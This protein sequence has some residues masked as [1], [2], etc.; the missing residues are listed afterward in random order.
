MQTKNS[1]SGTAKNH[2]PCK[3]LRQTFAAEEDL[4]H[5]LIKKHCENRH[6]NAL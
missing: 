3:H 6:K 2:T 4:L 1:L 5:A